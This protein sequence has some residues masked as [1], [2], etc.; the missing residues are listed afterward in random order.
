MGRHIRPV[1]GKAPI[2]PCPRYCAVRVES[3][4]AVLHLCEVCAAPFTIQEGWTMTPLAVPP[5]L[6][7]LAANSMDDAELAQS[8]WVKEITK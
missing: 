1:D 5:A 4:F 6:D 2:G 3:D 7:E 8:P